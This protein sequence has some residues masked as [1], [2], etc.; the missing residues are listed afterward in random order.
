M[1]GGVKELSGKPETKRLKWRDAVMWASVV[2]CI[3]TGI[4]YGFLLG[5]VFGQMLSA[6][7]MQTVASVSR[8][9]FALAFL[10]AALAVIL[11]APARSP[12]THSKESTPSG[13]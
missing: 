12:G 8:L 2:T 11:T 5:Q 13:R 3:L 4:F 1:L 10:V 7:E 9:T 6:G